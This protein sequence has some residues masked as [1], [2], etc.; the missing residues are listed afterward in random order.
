MASKELTAEI[1]GKVQGV[2]FRAY[3]SEQAEELDLVGYAQNMSEGHVEVVAQ[4]EEKKLKTFVKHLKSGP[5]FAEVSDIDI[6]WH[7][8]LQD[9]FIEF[10]IR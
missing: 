2:G 3:L 1:Y 7:D 8:T 9:T 5:H 4:G 6:E 10:K